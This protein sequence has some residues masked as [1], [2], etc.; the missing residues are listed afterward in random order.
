[1]AYNVNGTTNE[2]GMIRLMV[3]LT[4]QI[5]DKDEHQTFYVIQC[6]NED[7]ILG[8]PWLREA[9]PSIDWAAGTVM[10]PDAK[11]KHHW[12]LPRHLCISSDTMDEMMI[13]PLLSYGKND[14]ILQD[15]P[16][17]F[18]EL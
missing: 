9:N 2:N 10:L 6:G 3:L 8:L 1:M 11:L 5:G 17:T 4:L 14:T 12:T 15:M 13:R 7:I 16:S 18:N